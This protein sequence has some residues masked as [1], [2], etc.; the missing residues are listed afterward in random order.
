MFIL[1]APV[2]IFV[3]NRPEH[4]KK[5]IEAL[6]ENYLA[7]ET[8]VFIFS[9]GAKN[10]KATENVQLTRKYIDCIQDKNLFESVEIVKAPRNKG[11]A[12]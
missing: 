6:A 4:T 5:T 8:D 2:V 9:D 7:K 10:D 11:L 3:Y 1:P 12:N